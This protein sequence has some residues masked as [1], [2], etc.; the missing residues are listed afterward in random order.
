MALRRSTRMVRGFGLVLVIGMAAAAVAYVVREGDPATGAYRLVSLQRGDI[1]SVVS[2]TGTLEPVTTVEIGTQVSGIIDELL[3]DFNDPV[4]AGQVVARLDT[5]LLE[6]SVRD[7]RAALQRSQA[8]FD[9]ANRESE[10]LQSLTAQG[11]TS[12]SDLDAA[13]Y[14]LAIASAGRASAQVGLDRA[15]QNLE[16]A[17]I[18]TP[19]SGVVVERN[20]DVGQTVAASLQTPQLMVVAA[21]LAMM[22]ILVSVDESDIGL[23]REGQTVEFTVQAHG[24]DIF[25]GTVRQVRLQ[26][27]TEE[28]VVNY[29]VVVDVSNDDGRLLPGMTATVDFLVEEAAD[30]LKVA[31]AALRFRPTEAMIL[32]LRERRPAARQRP[33]DDGEHSASTGRRERPDGASGSLRDGFGPG[34]GGAPPDDV[35][36]L[37]FLDNEG[38]LSAAPVRTGLSDGQFTEISGPPVLTE[39][40]QVIAGTTSGGTSANTFTNPFQNNGGERQRMGPPPPGM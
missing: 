22:Q 36:V 16:Y 29:A 14:A 19:I 13:T 4:R 40:L 12:T 26:S 34:A 1:A 7:A 31:N 17:T 21:D 8:E 6:I 18:T 20:V 24:D 2:A 25:T 10:R 5:T 28:N 38:Q 39:G 37:F 9:D 27:T 30:V 11:I 15:T 35:K 33:Q 3:V 32:E 23:I